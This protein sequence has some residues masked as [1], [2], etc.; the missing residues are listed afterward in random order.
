MEVKI[1]YEFAEEKFKQA[2]ED[3]K[4]FLKTNSNKQ[5]IEENIVREKPVQKVCDFGILGVFPLS[6]INFE[7]NEDYSNEQIENIIV[8]IVNKYNENIDIFNNRIDSLSN[9]G[10]NPK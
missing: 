9:S 6:N 4:T 10:C 1:Q 7:S 8:G 3:I 5:I 2:Y